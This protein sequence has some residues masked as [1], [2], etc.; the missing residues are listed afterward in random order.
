MAKDLE[1]MLPLDHPKRI[2]IE[3]ELNKIIVEMTEV[4][5]KLKNNL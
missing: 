3:K 5:G 1:K 2:K 4:E